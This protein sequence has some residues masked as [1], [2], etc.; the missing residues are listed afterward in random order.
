MLRGPVDQTRA[1]GF[2]LC[3]TIN[4]SPSVCLLLKMKT[5]LTEPSFVFSVRLSETLLRVWRGWRP[6][7]SLFSIFFP[8]L[9]SFQL[10]D[11]HSSHSANTKASRTRVEQSRTFINVT[12]ENV[13]QVS[14]NVSTMSSNAGGNNDIIS[15][16]LLQY[17]ND[18]IIRYLMFKW[19]ITDIQTLLNKLH[20]KNPCKQHKV[21][22]FFININNIL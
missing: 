14:Y 13:S 6:P 16:I 15:T 11:L 20:F 5:Y 10:P 12:W 17:P 21:E 9:H 3:S 19:L 8:D 18:P 7:N 1:Y 4:Q 22:H 2:Q